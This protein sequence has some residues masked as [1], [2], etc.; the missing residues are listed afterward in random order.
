MKSVPS[1]IIVPSYYETSV[2]ISSPE[3]PEIKDSL[4][5]NGMRHSCHLA[6]SILNTVGKQLKVNNYVRPVYSIY[7]VYKGGIKL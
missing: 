1:N 3:S 6:R 7:C 5:I 2:P 4:Q